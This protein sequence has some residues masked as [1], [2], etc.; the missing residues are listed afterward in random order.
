[1]H[2]FV[3]GRLLDLHFDPFLLVLPTPLHEVLCSRWNDFAA[4]IVGFLGHFCQRE[5][6]RR[7]L[8]LASDR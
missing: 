4:R 7:C 6:F 3:H 2:T 8:W 1:M 5:R